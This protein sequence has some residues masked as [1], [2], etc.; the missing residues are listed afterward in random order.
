V[1]GEHNEGITG[2][3]SQGRPPKQ[4]TGPF[5][6]PT[7][8]APTVTNQAR[9]RTAQPDM[10]V[11]PMDGRNDSTNS[12]LDAALKLAALGLRVFPIRQGDKKPHIMRWPQLATCKPEKIT[13]WFAEWPD[14][15]VAVVIDRGFVLDA[16]DKHGGVASLK[17]LREE[18]TLPETAEAVTGGGGRHIWLSVDC[19]YRIKSNNTGAFR[20]GIDI[21]GCRSYVVVPP[22][23][24]ASGNT[25]E[26]LRRPEC[27]IADAP[28]W[29]IDELAKLGL[30]L[31]VEGKTRPLKAALE[32]GSLGLPVVLLRPGSGE[33]A[34]A[35]PNWHATSD[36]RVIRPMFKGKPTANIGLATG[37]GIVVVKADPSAGG[38][39]SLSKLAKGTT[40]VKTAQVLTGGGVR[41]L[42]FR[43][44][45]GV[46][47]CSAQGVLPGVDIV[48]DA[49]L[50]V[51][52]PS[53]DRETGRACK[54]KVHPRQGVADAPSWLVSFLKKRGIWD[55][56]RSDEDRSE[57]RET[58]PLNR[59]G[60]RDSLIAES[61]R[62]YP[63][64]GEGERNDVMVQ[65]LGSLLGR[66]LSESLS[67][68]VTLVWWKHFH[69]L[70]LIQTSP[71]EASKDIPA[72]MRSM[73]RSPN[74]ER[75][76]KHVDHRSECQAI[77]LED[78]QHAYMSSPVQA[79]GRERA[80]GAGEKIG[81][82]SH[83]IQRR[84]CETDLEHAFVEALI[85]HCTREA[86]SGNSPTRMT[87]DQV[88]QIV[89][90]RHPE[91]KLHRQVFE[92]LKRRYITRPDK[93]ATRRELLVQ[94]FKGSKARGQRVGLPS[95][96]EMTGISS[97]MSNVEKSAPVAVA[98][99]A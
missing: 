73:L 1:S 87:H 91:L 22:S 18:H 45:A 84:L 99:T 8:P 62:R 69:G 77:A 12:R 11:Y 74:F 61:V 53:I 36:S 83:V 60:D 14:A 5:L 65:V 31:E 13:E 88:R 32:Y 93:T 82:E 81:E 68:A 15:N 57:A 25:Y 54:W 35:G 6:I 17:Q 28:A 64:R 23:V 89:K 30:C 20:A 63:V 27:G 37:C 72:S 78:W 3:N 96:Y 51:V 33:P 7:R 79:R 50:I 9:D 56:A 85:V 66:G 75:P 49:G 38:I 76:D 71:D 24:H 42:I 40:A 16:D 29:L 34:I 4:A 44:P 41:N 67:Y 70:G 10:K 94:T 39:K 97:A 26:W 86:M 47:V 59:E 95:E 92:R 2:V 80:E 21:K 19:K 46:R 52:P 43:V 55:E 48:G 58:L 90:D 98:E